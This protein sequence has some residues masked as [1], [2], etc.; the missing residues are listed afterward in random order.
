MHE[1]KKRN[2]TI[3]AVQLNSQLFSNRF[4]L[5]E[6]ILIC[7][8]FQLKSQTNNDSI[9]FEQSINFN[10]LNSSKV[11]NL[12]GIQSKSNFLIIKKIELLNTATYLLGQENNYFT[13][14]LR[15]CLAGPESQKWHPGLG[16]EVGYLYMNRNF[17]E[18][19]ENTN[20][21]GFLFG[22]GWYF[23]LRIIS[24]GCVI[25]KWA[26]VLKPNSKDMTIFNCFVHW[27]LTNN[28][29]FYCGGDIYTQLGGYKYSG[30]VAGI[31]FLSWQKSNH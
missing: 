29:R 24:N 13:N 3:R 15:L 31:S 14:D 19:N 9:R 20:Q 5:I 17:L 11:S 30:F 2:L 25:A 4:F 28:L 8:T 26:Y 16:I 10:Q 27:N 18:I 21:H 7:L 12:W 23:P 22:G 6:I 1:L